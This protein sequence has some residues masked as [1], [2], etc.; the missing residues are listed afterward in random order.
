MDAQFAVDA[1]DVGF[2]GVLGDVQIAGHLGDGQ[3][4]RKPREHFAF[5]GGEVVRLGQ[6]AFGV[7]SFGPLVAQSC[8]DLAQLAA[9]MHL[10]TPIELLGVVLH[11]ALR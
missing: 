1:L 6:L 10:E 7:G 11:R 2:H 9:R 8:H 4:A 3:A 5:A